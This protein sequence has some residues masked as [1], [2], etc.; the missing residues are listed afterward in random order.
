M[1]VPTVPQRA[2][3]Y[4]RV[5]VSEGEV[6]SMGSNFPRLRLLIWYSNVN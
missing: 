1:R 2:A 4:L 3:L 6:R 5:E